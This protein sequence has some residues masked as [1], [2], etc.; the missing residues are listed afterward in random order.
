MFFAALNSS[1]GA[2]L[3]HLRLAAERTLLAAIWLHGPVLAAVGLL[4]GTN[5]WLALAL[6]AV[7]TAAATLSHRV[8]PGSAGTRATVAAVLCLLPGLFLVELVDHPWQSDLH[9]LFFAELATTAALL[10]LQA[11][12]VG[13]GVIALHH[14]ALNFVLPALVFPGGG[15]ILRVV[16]HAVIVV[17]ETG[18]LA[19]LVDQ[20]SR[21]LADAETGT[22][23]I[24]DIALQREAEQQQLVQA[25]AAAQRAVLHQTADAFEDRVSAL[26]QALSAKA[27]ELEETSG[28]LS[29]TAARANQQASDVK[30]AADGAGSGVGQVAQAAEELT[31]SIDQI[32]RQVSLSSR[33][34]G[35][36]VAD[37]RRTDAIVQALVDGA[38]KIGRVVELINSIAGQTN[39]L[40]LNATIEAARAGEAG[41]G[42]AVVATEVKSLAL[43]TARAT[44]EV[45]AQIG[46]IQAAAT[47]AVEAIRQIGTSIQEVDTIASAIAAAVEQQG[48]ATSAI[49]RSVAQTSDSARQV[50][51]NSEGLSAAAND[52]GAAAA[53][54]LDAAG[55]VSQQADRLAAEV[56]GLVA[57]LRGA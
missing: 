5:L 50:A 41:K 4:T 31:V 51:A 18:A 26:V 35:Q 22:V 42:F 27:G 14:L 38:G 25:A 12:L 19:W 21:A 34:T 33:A 49:S 10:D 9:M 46:Q 11:V 8:S 56:S 52:T 23:A 57:R 17:L 30:A 2:R 39:L 15:D 45:G 7:T 3:G 43:Q 24:A 16:L 54:V 55:G 29:S 44:E 20:A 28:S 37:A 40:A 6:W 13:A 47:Q 1:G 48:A 53:Q 32:G 36:A